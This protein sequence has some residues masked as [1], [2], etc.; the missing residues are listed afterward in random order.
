[1]DRVVGDIL[2]GHVVAGIKAVDI[3]AFGSAMLSFE[4]GELYREVSSAA[5]ASA[6][7][8]FE[9]WLTYLFARRTPC[10]HLFRGSQCW[11]IG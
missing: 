5:L 2:G 11:A 1:M 9:A 3:A 8:M 10:S 6:K 4:S 7:V